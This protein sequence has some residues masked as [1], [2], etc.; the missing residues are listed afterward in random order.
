MPPLYHI[1]HSFNP[2][3]RNIQT[4]Y[5][6]LVLLLIET[7]ALHKSVRKHKAKFTAAL[8]YIYLSFYLDFNSY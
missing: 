4:K 2:H 5:Y 8:S 3:S 1:N 7:L 6:S